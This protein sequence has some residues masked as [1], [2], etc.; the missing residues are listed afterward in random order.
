MEKTEK[1]GLSD[2]K[3]LSVLLTG[4]EPFGGEKVNPSM[5]IVKRLSKAVFPHISLHTLILP[6]SYQKSIEV[7][8]EYYKTNNIDIA[9]HL[10]QAGGSPGIRLE[11]VA[12]NLLDSKHP[13]NDGQIKEDVFIIDNGPDAYI[14]RVKIKAVAELLKKKKIPAFVSYTAG[15]YICNEVYY[16]SLHRSN[17]TGTPKHA[18]F[19]HLPFLPEQVATKEGKLDKLPSM[20]LELQTKAVRLILENLKEFI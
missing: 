7:L 9:L 8:E 3:K 12:I 10:G 6:V 2:S 13:D 20:T 19:V 1:S 16:Y 11:R 17:V 14:T 15:H 4:F 18:L 5:R